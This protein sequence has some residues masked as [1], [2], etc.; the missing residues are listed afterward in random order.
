MGNGDA[1]SVL[2][3]ECDDAIKQIQ[4]SKGVNRC[5]SHE[6]LARGIVILLRCEK[7]RAKRERSA[8]LWSVAGVATAFIVGGCAGHSPVFAKALGAV[9]E[10]WQ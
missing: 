5:E 9:L 10:A 7:A 3:G 8:R 2:I 4:H 1:V 6:P